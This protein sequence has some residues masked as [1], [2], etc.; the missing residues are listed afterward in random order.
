MPVVGRI[1][2]ITTEIYNVAIG[3]ILRTFFVS[4][5]NNICFHGKC[6]YYCDTGHAICGNPDKL[7]GSLAAYLPSS[8]LADRRV[9]SLRLVGQFYI[10]ERHCGEQV[11]LFA[12]PLKSH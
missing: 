5:A 4:P 10:Q 9:S 11:G 1:F 7:E 2:N 3:D 6:S 8:D 12:P